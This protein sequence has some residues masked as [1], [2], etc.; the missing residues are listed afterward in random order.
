MYPDP[1]RPDEELLDL[2]DINLRR[3]YFVFDEEFFLHIKGT[4]MGKSFPP[5]YANIFMASREREVF[6]KF[7]KKPLYYFRYL[8][9]IWGIWEGSREEFNVFLSILN[10]HDLSTRG[11]CERG[12]Y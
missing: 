6:V 5:L 8:D 4:A 12:F 7:K 10:G 3:N 9:D 2:L 1:N 11:G